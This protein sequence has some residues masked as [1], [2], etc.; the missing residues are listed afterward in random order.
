M[1][2]YWMGS[3]T[4]LAVWSWIIERWAAGPGMVI[5]LLTPR[6]RGY[7]ASLYMMVPVVARGTGRA[8]RRKLSIARKQEA[9]GPLVTNLAFDSVPVKALSKGDIRDKWPTRRA[10]L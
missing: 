7:A 4:A 1:E 10:P 5:L 9:S 8:T 3:A 6:P 2:P